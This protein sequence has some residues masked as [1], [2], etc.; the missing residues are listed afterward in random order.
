MPPP[1]GKCG[2]GG[3]SRVTHDQQKIDSRVKLGVE[4]EYGNIW[5]FS[6]KGKKLWRK[7]RFFC[8]FDFPLSLTL[9]P[10]FLT[11]GVD[12]RRKKKSTHIDLYDPTIPK[13][14]YKTLYGEKNTTRLVGGR[15]SQIRPK[16]LFFF[17]FH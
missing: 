13:N 14:R 6:P 10:V 11:Q 7:N 4:S 5:S 3:G 2:Q 16:N 1:E 9:T 17:L 15:F 8:D 12:L